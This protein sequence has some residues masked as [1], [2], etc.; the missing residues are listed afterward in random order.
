MSERHLGF[1]EYHMAKTNPN[2][3]SL[4][5]LQVISLRMWVSSILMPST[6]TSWMRGS[7]S[8]KDD[9]CELTPSSASLKVRYSTPSVTRSR[10]NARPSRR[11]R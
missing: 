3:P 6:L 4:I 11:K 9:T 8:M 10:R 5:R 1:H 7:E 2:P